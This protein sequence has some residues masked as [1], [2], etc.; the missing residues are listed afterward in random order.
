M[1]IYAIIFIITFVVIALLNIFIG[2]PNLGL[3]ILPIIKYT[4]L[5]IL[6]VVLIDAFLAL[7]IHKLPAKWFNHRFKR[8][9]IFKFERKFY[10]KIKIKK[11]KDLIPELGGLAD[12]R[13]NKIADPTNNEY[14]EKFLTECCYGEVIHL[15]SMFLGF[16]IIF[17]APLKYF[18]LFG[19]PVAIANLII[20][21]LSFMI[22]RYNRPKLAV[23]YE[24]NLR[25]MLRQSSKVIDK[26]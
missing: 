2:V 11:W 5:S 9:H 21:G 25:N 10:E 3:T 7:I 8:F 19:I 1:L 22:L 16:L 18:Y 6:V 20:N 13:K 23:L 26:A 15:T 12:F 4:G 14:I 17:V 24:R